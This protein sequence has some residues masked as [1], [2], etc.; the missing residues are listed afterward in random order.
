MDPSSALAK[1]PI[2]SDLPQARMNELLTACRSQRYE[3]NEAVVMEGD[4]GFSMF[5]VLAGQVEVSR[6]NEAGERVPFHRLGPGDHFGEMA[7]LGGMPRSAD[8]VTVL[9]SQLLVIERSAF[10]RSVLTTPELCMR[11][12]AHLC[13]RIRQSDDARLS[14]LSV[15]QRLVKALLELAVPVTSKDGTEVLAVEISR[16]QLADRILARR[17][18]VSREVSRLAAERL[19]RV[20]GKLVVIPR[21]E[22]LLQLLE[23]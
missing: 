7:L 21:P 17:E 12:L 20:R 14:K 16:Q 2:F 1:V 18:T 8:V 5:V 23:D 3:A 10:V 13:R 19:V 11:V 9:P 4:E 6:L 22:K 15:R